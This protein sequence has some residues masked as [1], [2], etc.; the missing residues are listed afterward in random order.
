MRRPVLLLG[1]GGL[2]REVLVAI[3]AGESHEP[4]GV[5]DDDPARWGE[6]ID[7][8]KV[9]GGAEILRDLAD[10]E[11]VLCAGKGTA[12]A[13]IAARLRLP[14][15]R[16]ATVTH[17]SVRIPPTCSIGAGTVLLAGSV[18]TTDVAVGC[19]VVAMP[20][21]V[22]T[23][24]DVVGN[25]ATLCAGVTLGGA[26]HIGPRAYIGMNAGVRERCRVGA[27]AVVGMGSVVLTDVPAG[28]TWAG[29]P[30]ARLDGEHR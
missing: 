8:V 22:L 7:G 3:R 14:T 30:A 5:V 29:V 6:L 9:L 4:V 12:R 15:A 16:Y 21:V 27:G 17:P 25:F 13:S 1:A 24:D 10:V 19:H 18:L 28:E 26:V 11:V 2:A 23:H 20:N